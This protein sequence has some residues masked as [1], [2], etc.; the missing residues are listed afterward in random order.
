M[1]KLLGVLENFNAQPEC[2]RGGFVARPSW[3]EFRQ[4]ASSISPADHELGEWQHGWQYYASSSLE[5]HFRGTIV[6]AQSSATDRAHLCSH[7]GPA[8]S[9]VC[10]S[11]H[12]SRV[13]NGAFTLPD[14]CLGMATA[15]SGCD[16]CHMHS[17]GRLDSLGRQRGACPESGRPRTRPIGPE[18]TICRE[19]GAVVRTNMKLRDKNIVVPANDEREIEV[20]WQWMSHCA[21]PH[22]LVVLFAPM[23][24]TWSAASRSPRQGDQVC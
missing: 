2:N 19:V 13:H 12:E 7:S 14:C 23:R 21:V 16:R 20:V 22:L 5:F 9:E 24:R 15:P 17:G 18:R 10:W 6:L 3:P 4:G 11:P 8:A 1:L